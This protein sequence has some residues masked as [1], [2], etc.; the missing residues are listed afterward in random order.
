MDRKYHIGDLVI[1]SQGMHTFL[2]KIKSI[3]T[4]NLTREEHFK[5]EIELDNKTIHAHGWSL[6]P[7]RSHNMSD[8]IKLSFLREKFKK[9]ATKR[10]E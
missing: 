6:K 8:E 5:F 3:L 1:V 4:Y 7:A 10:G 2:G 9:L